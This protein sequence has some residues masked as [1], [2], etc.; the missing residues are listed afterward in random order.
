[1]KAMPANP[2][3]LYEQFFVPAVFGPWARL[4]VE[5]AAPQPGERVLD[6]ACGTGAVTRIVA[7][8]VGPS[9]KL[10]AVDL[11][12][13]ML[14]TARRVTD[15][16]GAAVEWK[17][18]DAH[19]LPFPDGSFDLVC[20][21]QGVQFFADKVRALREVLRV[22]APG[23]RFVAACWKGLEHHQVF[24]ALFAAETRHLESLGV[25]RAEVIAPFS[26]GE[27]REFRALLEEAGFE[28]IDVTE[29]TL[30]ATFPADTFI[31][32]TEYAYGAVM[33]QFV[34]DP[35]RFFAFLEAVKRE[36]REIIERYRRGDQLTFA[37][38]ANVVI[39]HRG[40]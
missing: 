28:R 34:A 29:R 37:Q 7:P 11:R 36:T 1:M 18:A 2:A 3:D 38:H 26:F 19:A 12:A 22:L 14:A 16:A 24:E 15:S 20:C 25:T 33:P 31:D 13:G 23:G 35:A 32:K 8:A 39:A 30:D 9:G 17:E 4:L 5:R 6:L 21:Q 10:V 40:G 27:A